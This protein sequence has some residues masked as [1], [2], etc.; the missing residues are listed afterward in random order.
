MVFIRLLSPPL[1]NFLPTV[2]LSTVLHS[3][4]CWPLFSNKCQKKKK[5]KKKKNI[6]TIYFYVLV[7]SILLSARVSPHF[8]SKR[9]KAKQKRKWVKRNSDKRL[10]SLVLLWREMDFLHAKQNDAK[11][12]I[13]K[14]GKSFCFSELWNLAGIHC[15]PFAT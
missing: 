11:R 5:K 7:P 9:N 12:K 6:S 14:I 13:L 3:A 15:I 8:A 1:M 2:L 4:T 10:V